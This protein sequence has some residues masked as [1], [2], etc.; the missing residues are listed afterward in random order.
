MR[1]ATSPFFTVAIAA[2][3]TLTAFASTSLA[4]QATVVE[5][6]TIDQKTVTEVPPPRAEIRT[7][8]IEFQPASSAN[9]IN[10]QMLHD[11]QNAKAADTGIAGPIARNP[12]IVNDAGY[13]AKHP[14]LNAFLAKYP[15]AREEIVEN[16]GNFV[17][18]VA[19]SK[20]NSHE[21]AGIPRD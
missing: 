4:Q 13:V 7:T 21:V 10:T 20:W 19:G 16:P 18:P 14:A 9:D 1:P 5:K 8:E 6:T 3:L 15:D 12:S 11:F 2:A 17:T